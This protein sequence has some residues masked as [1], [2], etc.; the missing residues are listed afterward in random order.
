LGGNETHSDARTLGDS[1]NVG[2]GG[3]TS[4]GGQ[5]GGLVI[6][7]NFG[8]NW[9]RTESSNWGVTRSWSQT[10]SEAI[11]SNW[12]NAET[13]QRVYEYAVEPRTFQ[14]L[15]DYAL[16]LVTPSSGGPVVSAV[17][18]S[19]DIVSLPRVSLEPLPRLEPPQYPQVDGPIYERGVR[20]ITQP[21]AQ[22]WH[23]DP[24]S[25]PSHDPDQPG[26]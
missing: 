23:A 11:G 8:R 6:P 26:W 1:E 14:D 24:F 3:T 21:E 4:R 13:L 17:E 15:P 16:L 12:S 25:W 9:G 10:L 5:H 19:P 22:P 2:G 20:A 7:Q 18:C